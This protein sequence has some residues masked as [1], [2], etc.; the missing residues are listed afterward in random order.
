ML[1]DNITREIPLMIEMKSDPK[2]KGDKIGDETDMERIIQVFH[3]RRR[4]RRF[5]F[6]KIIYYD[7]SLYTLYL[8]LSHYPFSLLV[9]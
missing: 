7:I 9:S 2:T 3:L 4:R 1:K 8:Y 5:F 6:E